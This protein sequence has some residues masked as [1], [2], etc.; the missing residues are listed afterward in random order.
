MTTYEVFDARSG[1]TVAM[2][3][4]EAEARALIDTDDRPLDYDAVKMSPCYCDSA[5]HRLG[6]KIGA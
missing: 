3:A 6:H 2:V 5:Y 1:V 4:T